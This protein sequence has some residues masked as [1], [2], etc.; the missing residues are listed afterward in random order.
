MPRRHAGGDLKTTCRKSL[1]IF[2]AL[3]IYTHRI[4]NW[5]LLEPKVQSIKIKIF[6]KGTHPVQNGVSLRGTFP[7]FDFIH[8]HF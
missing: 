4:L 8:Q 2:T 3:N 5:M 7:L 1:G 6:V